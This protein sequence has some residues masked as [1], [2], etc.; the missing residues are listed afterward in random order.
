MNNS[1]LL[2]KGKI[3][4]AEVNSKEGN[5]FGKYVKVKQFL[6]EYAKNTSFS[7]QINKYDPMN[8]G[9]GNINFYPSTLIS[10]FVEYLEKGFLSEINPKREIQI[11]TVNDFLEQAQKLLNTSGVHP[12]A[13]AIIIGAA[14]EEFLRNWIESIDL[15]ITGS[16]SINTYASSLKTEKIITKQD[17]KDITS[18]A[19]IRN[20]AAHGKWDEVNSKDK[21]DLMLLGV[22]LFI[23]EYTTT[24]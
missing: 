24:T 2:E 3:L 19:G 16:K 10:S 4:L 23:R 5:S 20:S 13:P 1:E 14:L 11:E 9:L 21:V 6:N 17:V 12:A 7:E 8:E 22:N 18:W 15:Q